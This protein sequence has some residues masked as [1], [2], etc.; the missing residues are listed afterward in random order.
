MRE[1][2]GQTAEDRKTGEKREKKSKIR[3]FW[4]KF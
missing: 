1:N 2:G 3:G 4:G